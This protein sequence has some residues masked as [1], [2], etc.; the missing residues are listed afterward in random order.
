MTTNVLLSDT[1]AD[2]ENSHEAAVGGR[3]PTLLQPWSCRDV[4][5]SVFAAGVD[6][7]APSTLQGVVTEGAEQIFSV[8]KRQQAILSQTHP[9]NQELV[10]ADF[11]APALV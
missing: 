9:V 10:A 5:S 2:V 11:R 8:A 7:N 1:C 3:R 4:T 6:A